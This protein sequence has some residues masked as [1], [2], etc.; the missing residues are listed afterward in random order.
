MVDVSVSCQEIL[1]E[2]INL[3]WK[4]EG[5]EISEIHVENKVTI[6]SMIRNIDDGEIV[7]IEVWE[8]TDNET[9]D[10]MQEL[11]GTVEN[12]KIELEWIVVFDQYNENTN[13]EQ[14][15]ENT[16]YYQEIKNN[17]YTVLDYV[18]LIKYGEFVSQKSKP[19]AILGHFHYLVTYGKKGPPVPNRGYT[20][21]APDGKKIRGTTDEEGYIEINNLRIV[22]NYYIF[23]DEE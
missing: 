3:Q 20:L 22:G 5:A 15:N 2:F 23:V 8:E 17:G 11:E 13:Y 18:F 14:Y 16:S 6:S 4:N 7:K 12:G 9:K 10:L 21:Y 1:P 19:L